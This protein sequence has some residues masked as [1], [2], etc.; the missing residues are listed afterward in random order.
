M[1][2]SE[3]I[4]KIME[5]LLEHTHERLINEELVTKTVGIRL[6]DDTFETTNRSYSFN[7]HTDDYYQIHEAIEQLFEKY[8]DHK[9]LRLI[10]VFF[11]SV[12]LK[13]DLKI[14]INLFNYQEMTKREEKLYQK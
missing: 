12:I 6:R 13:R 5:E 3:A 11:G 2:S 1:D 9:P 7:E 14:D 10:G 8:Y 4:F